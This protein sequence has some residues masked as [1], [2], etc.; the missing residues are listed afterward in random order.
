MG[1]L[2]PKFQRDASHLPLSQTTLNLFPRTVEKILHIIDQYWLPTLDIQMERPGNF[3]R[4]GNL[5]VFF[6]NMREKNINKLWAQ[7]VTKCKKNSL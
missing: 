1:G 7:M 2:V 5:F 4:G 6:L 3:I